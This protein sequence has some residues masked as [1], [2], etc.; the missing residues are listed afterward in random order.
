MRALVILGL[1]LYSSV[2]YAADPPS[3]LGYNNGKNYVQL[4]SDD[5][6]ATYAQGFINGITMHN[7]FKDQAVYNEFMRCTSR[8][9]AGQIGE[10]IRQYIIN[11][12]DQQNL[13]LNVL[14]IYALNNVCSKH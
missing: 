1:L 4:F 7:L 12:P 10:V 13:S 5:H 9:K 11:H 14:S 3:Y 6:R 8:M 2:G